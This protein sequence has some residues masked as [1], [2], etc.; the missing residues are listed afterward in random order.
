MSQDPHHLLSSHQSRVASYFAQAIPFDSFFSGRKL[1]W[2]SMKPSQPERWTELAWCVCKLLT[3]RSRVGGQALSDG[4]H[5]SVEGPE[6]PCSSPNQLWSAHQIDR[7][8][9]ATLTLHTALLPRRPQCPTAPTYTTFRD[10]S[11][12]RA[13]TKSYQREKLN[14]QSDAVSVTVVDESIPG[15]RRFSSYPNDHRIGGDWS[16]PLR[17][18]HSGESQR[19]AYA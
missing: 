4:P 7:N 3:V 11:P 2:T 8:E 15:P 12:S 6:A 16:D 1:C 9:A 17:C 13:I 14:G 18:E 10:V 5:P 19:N